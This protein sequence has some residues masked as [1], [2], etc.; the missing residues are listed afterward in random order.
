V[1]AIPTLL[2][3]MRCLAKMPGR[4][5]PNTTRLIFAFMFDHIYASD[6][7]LTDQ[8]GQPVEETFAIKMSQMQLH[9]RIVI[10]DT[11][12]ALRD[13]FAREISSPS[14]FAA[15]AS[16]EDLSVG[17]V[18]GKQILSPHPSALANVVVM[19]VMGRDIMAHMKTQLLAMG[20]ALADQHPLDFLPAIAFMWSKNGTESSIQFAGMAAALRT[21]VMRNVQRRGQ[22]NPSCCKGSQ[23]H[24]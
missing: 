13:A 12:F 21:L 19:R 6:G 15:G 23:F 5:V 14:S 16:W 20:G 4:V 2:R 22:W 11:V 10:K 8:S 7:S 9:F 3:R 17:T 1:D 24:H 18:H